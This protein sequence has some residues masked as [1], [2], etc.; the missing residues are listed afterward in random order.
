MDALFN[1]VDVSSISTNVSAILVAFIGINVL[2]VG[3]GY[4]KRTFFRA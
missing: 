2:F 1:A 3:Y 4:I